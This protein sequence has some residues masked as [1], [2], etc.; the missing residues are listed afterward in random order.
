MSERPQRRANTKSSDAVMCKAAALTFTIKF[1][2][3]CSSCKL[4]GVPY[5]TLSLVYSPYCIVS[6]WRPGVYR[7]LWRCRVETTAIRRDRARDRG[8]HTVTQKLTVYWVAGAACLS[9]ASFAARAPAL[10]SKGEAK[11][12]PSM[13]SFASC[14]CAHLRY[15]GCD[16]VSKVSRATRSLT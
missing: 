10:E 1:S 7:A 11:P 15:S 5:C 4:L 3:A 8:V 12:A 6:I 2:L 16:R 13:S 9:P 14:R